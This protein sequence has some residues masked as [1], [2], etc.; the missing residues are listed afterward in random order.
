MHHQPTCG[1][2]RPLLAR[3]P[4]LVLALATALPWL[5]FLLLM[6]TL[7]SAGYARADGTAA[8]TGEMAQTTPVC[9]GRSLIGE[10]T[11]SHPE[12][13]AEALKQ[14]DA[15]PNGDALLWKIEKPGVDPSWLFGTMH[16]TD[17]EVTE[18]PVP[19][20]EAFEAAS[21]VVIETIDILDPVKAQ[22]ALMSNPDLTMFTDGT[23]LISLLSPEDAKIVEA[24][25]GRRGIPMAL[26][27]RMKPWII[28]GM[29]GMPPC[30]A[31]RKAKG[32]DILDV[33]IA[34]MAGDE[35]KQVLGLETI[36]EQMAALTDLPMEFHL[37]GLVETIKLADLMPD[38]LAT[39]S[40]LYL[41]GR[42]SAIMPVIQ[43]AGPEGVATDIS[44]YAAF[45]ERVITL[46]NHIMAERAAPILDKGGAFIAVGAMHLPGEEGLVSLLGQAGYTISAMR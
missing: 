23:T 45:E 1:Q 17:P 38:I 13:M 44:G 40:D 11:A 36:G 9:Q 27:A 37:R 14:A 43:A 21:T 8:G 31:A 41:Q 16:V 42:V 39:M 10:L 29:V 6:I 18:M 24:E 20:R 32:I 19:A 12:R 4:D 2:P 7:L 5:L 46:R 34:K 30:E 3:L 33:N 26:V 15:A 25:L 22:A 28:T 35:G